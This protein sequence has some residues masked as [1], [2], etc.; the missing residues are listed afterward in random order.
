MLKWST[1]NARQTFLRLRWI[2]IAVFLI[3]LIIR[4]ITIFEFFA[5]NRIVPG[6]LML[7]SA[8]VLLYGF[9]TKQ[10]LFRGKFLWWLIAFIGVNVISAF[11]N[12][13]LGIVK[14]LSLA[15]YYGIQ[16]ILIYSVA[17]TQSYEENLRD[18][19]R[20]NV[21][22]IVVQFA[23]S[24][25]AILMFLYNINITYTTKALGKIIEQG[26]QAQYGRVWGLYYEANFL[27]MS[28]LLSILFSAFNL[29]HANATWKKVFY[30]IN[31]VVSFLVAV[32]SGSRTVTLAMYA[33]CIIYGFYFV[34]TQWKFVS[35]VLFSVAMFAIVYFGIGFIKNALPVLQRGFFRVAP[36]STY[37]MVADPIF[38]LYAHN[39]FSVKMSGFGQEVRTNQG[40]IQPG[41]KQTI[42]L[43]KPIQPL[44]RLDLEKTDDFSNRR[45]EVWKDGLNVFKK[46]PIFGVSMRN[47]VD[48]A[49]KHKTSTND[50]F[51]KGTTLTNMYLE[52]LVGLGIVGFVLMFGFL[53]KSAWRMLSFSFRATKHRGD[54]GFSLMVIVA[55][56]IF[57]IML[58]D[59]LVDFSTNSLAFWMYLGFGMGVIRHDLEAEKTRKRTA[60][61]V[62]TP[63]QLFNAVNMA[64]EEPEK[65]DL[66]VYKQF[67]G[68]DQLV[69]RTIEAGVFDEVYAFRPIPNQK[70]WYSPIR[71]ALRMVFSDRVLRKHLVEHHR[72]GREL[73][74]KVVSHTAGIDAGHQKKPTIVD[75]ITSSVYDWNRYDRLALSFYTQFT[76]LLRLQF[77]GSE[78]VQYEDGIGTYTTPNLEQAYRSKVYAL[79]NDWILNGQLSYDAKE[80][81]VNA[82]DF[83]VGFTQEIKALPPL[84]NHLPVLREIF[85]PEQEPLEGKYDANT[86]L[87]L[88]QP[89][90]EKAPGRADE[91]EQSIFDRIRQGKDAV[92]VRVHPRQDKT[93]YERFGH[94]D[95]SERIWELECASK[96]LEDATIAA[97]FSSAQFMP[98]L[99]YQKEP[100]LVFSYP[101]YGGD[102]KDAQLLVERL[103]SCYQDPSRIEIV[104]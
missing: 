102:W 80:V 42:D 86:L 36:V 5:A 83:A 59:V 44:E 24:L 3:F 15:I 18:I 85:D 23:F 34:R 77:E 57:G 78:V 19:R 61:V 74:P 6:I 82:P 69:A 90:E 97:A 73:E 29:K 43:N 12:R 33:L 96:G 27:G 41:D 8:I 37:H 92:I 21:V 64:L 40:K 48:Y 26:Y 38:D 28:A 76:D 53:L 84:E 104:S 11:L 46:K 17:C 49:K 52:L 10:R 75:R 70:V 20:F 1:A 62:D 98:Y 50:F 16:I 87:Y 35:K 7:F 103:Q 65:P 68:A 39:G 13:D 95:S 58:S 93:K 30:W 88:T 54:V 91:I 32:L 79:V 67:R 45:F 89:L 66:F 14:S 99:L 60:Y 71:S 101:A 4:K 100:R 56:M 94:I 63:L 81:F 22:F 55:L 51:L 72:A 2:N 25:I 9:L 47:V 31:I